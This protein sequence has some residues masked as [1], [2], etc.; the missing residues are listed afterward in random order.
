MGY[1][2]LEIV[3][4]ILRVL[5]IKGVIIWHESRIPMHGTLCS[6]C[7]WNHP[8]N[9]IDLY[10]VSGPQ[11]KLSPLWVVWV[12]S[13]Q[14]Y[15]AGLLVTFFGMMKWPFSMVILRDLQLGDL[16]GHFEAPGKYINVSCFHR[17][18]S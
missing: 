4:K 5:A 3:M 7:M 1:Y 13:T 17:I 11:A 8:K 10:E 15:L 18:P 12:I 16:K 9:T 2:V 6:S 14:K